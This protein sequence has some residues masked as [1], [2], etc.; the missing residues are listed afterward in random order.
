[1]KLVLS[2]A[3]RAKAL[4][5]LPAPIA[6]EIK[7]AE[8]QEAQKEKQQEAQQAAQALAVARREKIEAL[9]QEWFPNAFCGPPRVPLAIGIHKRI[10]DVA[11]DDIAPK[12]AWPVPALVVLWARATP[13]VELIGAQR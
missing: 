10:L 2:P 11:A 13:Y 9:L 12:R 6:A 5:K 1:M 3:Q 7:Q 8:R 4:G